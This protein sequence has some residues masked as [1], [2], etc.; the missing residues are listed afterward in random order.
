MRK[1]DRKKRLLKRIMKSSTCIAI[2]AV[3]STTVYARFVEMNKIDAAIV[4]Q[5]AEIINAQNELANI[6]MSNVVIEVIE[7]EPVIVVEEPKTEEVKVETP[8][9]QE[10]KKEEKKEVKK[11]TTTTKTVTSTA[12]RSLATSRSWNAGVR[13]SKPGVIT[14]DDGKEIKY[15]KV[16]D[17]YATA[18]CACKSCCGKSPSH[19]AYGITAMGTKAAHGTVAVDPRVISLGSKLYIEGIGS[20]YDYGYSQALDTGRSIKGNKI[21]LYFESHSEALKWGKKKVRVYILDK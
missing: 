21:D 18:Y 16:I 10:V 4:A 9:K 11:T 15:K 20:T 3:L 1:R 17:V 19:P 6:D 7:D 12:A 14:T 5:E 2:A 13:E 8:T